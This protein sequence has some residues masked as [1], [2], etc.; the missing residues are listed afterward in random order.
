[1]SQRVYEFGPYQLDASRCL[2]QRAGAS[3]AL[4]PK[5]F[6]ILLALIECRG[7]VVSKDELMRRVWP[8]SFVEEGN[9]TYNIS[10]LRK[11]LGERAGEHQ[12]I[13]TVPGRGYRFV[14]EV[15]EAASASAEAAAA[16]AN[17]ALGT[18]APR[19]TGINP[20]KATT[21]TLPARIGQHRSGLA[22]VILTVAALL[23]VG[24]YLL[25]RGRAPNPVS[26]GGQDPIRTLAVLPLANGSG[27][28]DTEY[29]SDGISES[30]INSLSQ[31]PGLKVI[32]RSS[33]FKYKGKEVDAQE[34]AR[35]LGVDA[36]VT[37]RVLQRGDALSISVELVDARDKTQVWG[38]RYDRRATDLLAVQSEI[39][40]EIVRKL[41]LK[42]TPAEQRQLAR[43]ETV[44]PQA[45]EL[46]LKGRFYWNKGGTEN[47]KKAVEYLNQAIAVDPAY[48]LA[49]AEL[50]FRYGDLVAVGILDPKE[51]TPKAEAAA[52][53]ALELDDS[54][55]EAHLARGKTK[56]AAWDWAAAEREFKRAIELNPNLDRARGLYAFYLSLM[57][58]HDEAIAEGKRIRELD[59]LSPVVNW[60]I[61]YRLLLARQNDQAIEAAKKALELGQNYP[62]A[63]NLLG[64]AY[65]AKGQY[66]EAIA[67]YQQAVR[68]GNNSPDTE[69]YLGA[70]YAKAGELKKARA[71]LK[72]LEASQPYV[73]PGTLAA[74][75]VALGE[76]EQALA[77]L[78]RA[79]AAHDNQLQ[80][81]RVDPNLDPLRS[82]PRFQDLLRRVGLAQ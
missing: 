77:S 66:R 58:R 79:Y 16:E 15:S 73:S 44:D 29:L 54:L 64:Y 74:L 67:A 37:G 26:V 72:Q 1:M 31:L 18:S 76:H 63:H 51:F 69:I 40:G 14:A 39:S 6:D 57:G 22:I 59:P 82:D 49:Y 56:L 62:D 19:T 9:L 48:A 13:L 78:E 24:V 8:D 36:I 10:V 47:R 17:G 71:I 23:I 38:E 61:G 55:A 65:A 68:L 5:A 2:L 27:D 43:R 45:Y 3:V 35:A 21:A 52:Q 60:R 12:Y 42:L 33:S 50:S 25:I 28:S 81:L 53:T 7:E 34:V 4:T 46:L 70:A 80:F 20:T 30:L 32:A 11:A 41:R 75:Y